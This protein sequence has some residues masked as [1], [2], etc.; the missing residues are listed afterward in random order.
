MDYTDTSLRAEDNAWS[1]IWLDID[2]LRI[3]IDRGPD[4]DPLRCVIDGGDLEAILGTLC[5]AH[6]RGVAEGRRSA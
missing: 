6:G 1:I 3:E 4:L 2:R 5:V